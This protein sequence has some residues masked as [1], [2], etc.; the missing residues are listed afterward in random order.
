M[1]P[2]NILCPSLT[3]ALYDVAFARMSGHD[4]PDKLSF[5]QV[6]LS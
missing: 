1:M 2:T 3:R 6:R 5:E 4:H